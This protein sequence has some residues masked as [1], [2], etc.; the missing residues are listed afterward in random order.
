MVYMPQTKTGKFVIR[1][2]GMANG[3]STNF[4][5]MYLVSFDPDLRGGRGL[6]GAELDIKKAKR[7]DTLDEVLDFYGQRSKRFPNRADGQPNRPLTAMTIQI[8]EVQE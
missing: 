7:F 6:V 3:L 2:I 4:D 1:L 8:I 5:G